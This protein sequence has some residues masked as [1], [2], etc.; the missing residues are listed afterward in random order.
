MCAHTQN[1]PRLLGLSATL[2]GSSGVVYCWCSRILRNTRPLQWRHMRGIASQNPGYTTICLTHLPLDKMAAI[3]ADG[4]FNCIFL[5]END[6]IP[7]Q[8][9]L[10][11][12]PMS[13]IDNKPELVQVMAWRRAGDKP[14]P[15]PMI[16]QF[17]DAYMRHWGEMSSGLYIQANNKEISEMGIVDPLWGESTGDCRH[18]WSVVLKPLT[19]MT[20]S[21]RTFWNVWGKLKHPFW[22]TRSSSV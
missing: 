22:R 11:Y 4:N 10:K 18:K 15:G 8:I 19:L 14:L 2:P 5:N 16:T 17:I 3:L 12:V 6:R 7:I 1:S 13:P 21:Y 20:L 9:S